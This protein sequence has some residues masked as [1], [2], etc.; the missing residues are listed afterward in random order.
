MDLVTQVLPGL[1]WDIVTLFPI[2]ASP[3]VLTLVL[4]WAK[5]D[6]VTVLNNWTSNGPGDS[7]PPLGLTVP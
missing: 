2:W 1:H 3:G 4:N 7:G 5:L 6:P